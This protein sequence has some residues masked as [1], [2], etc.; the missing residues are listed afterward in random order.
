[1]LIKLFLLL[2]IKIASIFTAWLPDHTPIAWPDLG[3]LSTL[4]APVGVLDRWVHLPVIFSML[5]LILWVELCILLYAAVRAVY[6][7]IPTFK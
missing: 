1:M 3:I 2:L 4:L 7:F 5:A 6:G